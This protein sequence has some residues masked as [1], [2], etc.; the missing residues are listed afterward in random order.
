MLESAGEL[1]DLA[2]RAREIAAEARAMDIA[3]LLHVLADE[4]EEEAFE[5]ERATTSQRASRR[6]A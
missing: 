4:L 1:R 2:L 3:R 6:A 5:L